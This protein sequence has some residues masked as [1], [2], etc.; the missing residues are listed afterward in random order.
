MNLADSPPSTVI[1]LEQ[2]QVLMHYA[3][4]APH[5]AIAE[6]G[7]YRGG[8]AW[9]LAQ[10]GRPLF[11]YDTFEGIP[12][13]GDL[14]GNH[15]GKFA[16]TSMEAVQAAVPA[17]TVVKGLF[18]TS[19]V[20]MPPLAFVHVDCDQYASVRACIETFP[21]LMVPGGFMLFDDFGVPDCQGA[22]QAVV[23]SGIPFL[24]IPGTGRALMII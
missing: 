3:S 8:S 18:P 10:L 22:T 17:A 12:F 15:V 4:R 13:Q 9:F 24:V 20:E 2:M 16:D 19:L 6:V 21:R 7:V 14:D 23:E 1:P 11:L 5:G